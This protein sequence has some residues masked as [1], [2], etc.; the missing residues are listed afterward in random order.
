MAFG[1]RG[2]EGGAQLLDLQA[3]ELLRVEPGVGSGTGAGAGAGAGAGSVS[4]SAAGAGAARPARRVLL[5]HGGAA[6]RRAR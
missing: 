5:L 4:A 3:L 2:L 1:R 6:R